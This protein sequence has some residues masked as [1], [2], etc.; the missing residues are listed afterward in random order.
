MEVLETAGSAKYQLPRYQGDS[1][2]YRALYER[3]RAVRRRADGGCNESCLVALLGCRTSVGILV[4]SI[5]NRWRFTEA[6]HGLGRNCP[7]REVVFCFYFLGIVLVLRE[8]G[9]ACYPPDS[10]I[11][12]CNLKLSQT[13]DFRHGKIMSD[14]RYSSI[15]SSLLCWRNY[16]LCSTEGEIA[17]ARAG[18]GNIYLIDKALITIAGGDRCQ[19]QFITCR[20]AADMKQRLTID[21]P[22]R[23]ALVMQLI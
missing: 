17:T 14:R 3:P 16:F 11:Q 22:A 18:R 9:E 7:G 10:E 13:S 1:R 12:S 20:S 5:S 2:R 6:K 4:T 23:S 21:I 15:V 8:E 19:P